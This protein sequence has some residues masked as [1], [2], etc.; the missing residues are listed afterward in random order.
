MSLGWSPVGFYFIFGVLLQYPADLP[1]KDLALFWSSIATLEELSW[2]PCCYHML[3]QSTPQLLSWITPYFHRTLLFVKQ[4][5]HSLY[6]YLFVRVV[7][8]WV[9]LWLSPCLWVEILCRWCSQVM[10]FCLDMIACYLWI[11]SLRLQ[12]WVDSFQSWHLISWRFP[13]WR[14]VYV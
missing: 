10:N 14:W 11:V 8:Q 2:C 5:N 6:H 13:R 1:T 4:I 7:F 12:W 3:F 9:A